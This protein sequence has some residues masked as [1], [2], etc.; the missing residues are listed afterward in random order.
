MESSL[1]THG[2]LL[3]FQR[4]DLVELIA[5]EQDIE[6]LP[7]G[8]R[9]NLCSQN[10]NALWYGTAIVKKVNRIV[11]VYA[12]NMRLIKGVRLIDNK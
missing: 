2:D 6:L 10:G 9:V 3:V 11:L 4:G 12:S 8:T 7:K 1:L 5:D